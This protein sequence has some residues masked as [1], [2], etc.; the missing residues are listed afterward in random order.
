MS[1]ISVKPRSPV[2]ASASGLG[3]SYGELTDQR[4]KGLRRH[5]IRSPSIPKNP[6]F[7]T[8]PGVRAL[9]ARPDN[10]VC[11]SF[12]MTGIKR[13]QAQQFENTSQPYGTTKSCR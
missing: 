6:S 11:Q 7:V 3:T 13:E 2:R 1:D 9:H 5:K 4:L 12:R 8:C 10:A